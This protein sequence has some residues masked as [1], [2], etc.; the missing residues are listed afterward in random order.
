[1]SYP[2]LLAISHGYWTLYHNFE[3]L[4]WYNIVTY[5]WAHICILDREKGYWEQYEQLTNKSEQI[6][7]LTPQILRH[8]EFSISLQQLNGNENSTIPYFI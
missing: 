8:H 5:D 4:L 2:V 6:P 3:A 1:M 7:Q